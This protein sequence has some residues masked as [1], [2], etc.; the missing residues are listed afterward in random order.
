MVP[1]IGLIL[2]YIDNTVLTL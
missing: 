1:N 2:I